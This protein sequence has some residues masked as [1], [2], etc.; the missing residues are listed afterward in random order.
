MLAGSGNFTH[1]FEI[2]KAFLANVAAYPVGTLVQL[3][4]GDVGV[5]TGT[6]R[7]HS[8]R[9]RVRLLYRPS[10]EPYREQ[11]TLDLAVEM[12]YYVSHLLPAEAL[13][14]LTCDLKVAEGDNEGYRV[15]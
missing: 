1:D 2:V 15:L 8:H 5:V 3:N 9:P 6:A 7:G 12:D 13:L 4:S 14:P 11:L 10:G